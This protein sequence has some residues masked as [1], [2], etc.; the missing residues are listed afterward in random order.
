MDIVPTIAR[1]LGIA[2]NFRTQG[3]DVFS[4]PADTQANN[5]YLGN[6]TL[7]RKMDLF[8]SG[9]REG[10]YNI[11]VHRQ[12]LGQQRE[13]FDAR[14]STTLTYELDQ[15]GYLQEVDLNAPFVPSRL[16]GRIHGISADSEAIDIAVALN[17]KIVAVA[18]SYMEN[19]SVRF[20]VLLPDYEFV[21]GE[22]I[23]ELF[24]I[25]AGIDGQ[26]TLETMRNPR[27]SQYHYVSFNGGGNGVIADQEGN[28]IPLYA[29]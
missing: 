22:N 7:Q 12:L 29:E 18:Q 4:R 2:L 6:K 23:V 3:R 16:T 10:L 9:D 27:S 8:G 17:N 14:V 28:T 19:R 24:R 26:L 11:G 21:A 5:P 20:S 15:Q 13:E 1:M 25:H